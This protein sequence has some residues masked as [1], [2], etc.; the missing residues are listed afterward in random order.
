VIVRRVLVPLDG[1][2]LAESVLPTAASVAQALRARVVL[3]H[4]LEREAPASVH[5]EA[6]LTTAED[7][8]RYLESHATRL[9]SEGIDVLVDVHDRPVHD[10]AVALDEHAHEL[11]A[12]LIAMCAH[13]RTNLRDRAL[14]TIAEQ[15]LRGGSVPILLRT[16]RHPHDA[17]FRLRNLLVPVD[18]DHDVDAALDAAR[19]LAGPYNAT[20]TLLT[21]SESP[22]AARRFLP[23][24]SA[25]ARQLDQAD[26]EQR[27]DALVEGLRAERFE[28]RG[29][30]AD[31]EPPAAIA[32]AR[33]SLP[34]ELIVVVTDVHG[35]LA[36]WY[37]PS[38]LQRLL[39][40]PDLTLLLIR[41]L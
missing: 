27:L 37:D 14:G 18:F 5:G 23:S 24:A 17:G 13:G 20:I 10:V 28:A 2:R 3:L 21:V 36:S 6:H 1:S 25:R 38:T 35:G 34:A 29:V 41:E 9:R 30:V 32:A 40:I 7:A 33:E 8:R 22:P 11:D 19:T 16:V 26:A 39:A 12:D 31:D 15:I 4:V